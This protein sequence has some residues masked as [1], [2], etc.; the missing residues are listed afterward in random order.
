MRLNADEHD[1]QNVLQLNQTAT[2]YCKITGTVNTQKRHTSLYDRGPASRKDG[3]QLIVICNEEYKQY[4]T[5]S[6]GSL[7]PA[8]ML[9]VPKCNTHTQTH[10]TL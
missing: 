10:T 6:T 3:L 4:S 2:K 7:H 1:S 5:K 9:H 8:S